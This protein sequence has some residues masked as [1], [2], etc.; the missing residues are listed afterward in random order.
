MSATAALQG[1]P[2]IEVSRVPAAADSDGATLQTVRMMAEYVRKCVNDSQVQAAADYAWKRFAMGS[3]D[4][5]AKCWGVFWW[6]KH[7]IKFRLDEATM[8]RVGE[9]DQQDFLTAPDVLLR[10]KEPAE[11]CDGFTMLAAAMLTVLG[12]PVVIAT[13]A[14]DGGDPSRWSHVFLCALLP[15]DQVLPLD[16]SHGRAPGW[17]VPQSDIHRWQAWDLNG[18]PVNIRPIKRGLHGYVKR[19]RTIRWGKSRNGMGVLCADGAD[20]ATGSCS[21][22]GGVAGAVYTPGAVPSPAPLTLPFPYGPTSAP[23]PAPSSGPSTLD[24]LFGNLALGAENIFGK[25]V[26]PQ[27]QQTCNA[28][29][30]TTTVAGGGGGVPAGGIPGVGLSSNT[31]LLAGGGLLA[32]M[33]VMMMGKK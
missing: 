33:V 6:V 14:A 7:C 25:V 1:S 24:T 12:V 15:G 31:L 19:G 30:C 9:K 16:T 11:D 5:A 13:V 22:D 4:P 18:N 32:L 10:M 17:M 27:Y 2:R 29:G 23:T 20:D 8:F 3:P 26:A 28:A 21:D